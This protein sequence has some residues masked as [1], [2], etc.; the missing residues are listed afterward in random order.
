M[1]GGVG[2]KA[3][4]GSRA[5]AAPL[6]PPFLPPPLHHP[7]LHQPL[8]APDEQVDAQHAVALVVQLRRGRRGRA[9]ELRAGSRGRVSP[10]SALQPAAAETAGTCLH[11]PHGAGLLNVV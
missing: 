11:V 5:L 2:C 3:V 1:E 10:A 9:G 7:L 4:A 6:R 8:A